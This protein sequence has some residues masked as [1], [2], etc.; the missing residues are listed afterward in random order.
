MT[1][2]KKI[3]DGK[4]KYLALI[5]IETKT[6]SVA[7]FVHRNSIQAVEMEAESQFWPKDYRKL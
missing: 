4:R 7:G 1:R 6:P 3:Q 2:E 5:L